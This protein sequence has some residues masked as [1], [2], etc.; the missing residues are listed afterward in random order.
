MVR[1]IIL[2]VI[3]AAIIYAYIKYIERKS[4]FFPTDIISATPELVGLPFQDVYL[5][6]QDGITIHGWFLPRK[7]ARYTIL[8]LHGNGGNVG[9]RLEKLLLLYGAGVNIFIIDYRGFGRSKGRPSEGGVYL[10]AQAS[11]DYLLKNK[12]MSPEKIILYGESLGGAVAIDLAK[13]R[14]VG[15]LIV[16][17]SFSR[18]QDMAKVF[19]PFLPAFLFA[20]TF[21]SL[22][23]IDAIRAPTLFIHSIDDE[24][25]P[26]RLAQKLYNAAPVPKEF[27]QIRGSHNTAFL[28]SKEKY[29][30]SLSSYLERLP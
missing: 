12:G 9:H 17:G 6:T 7:D 1:I 3:C 2:I 30:T 13:R 5:D 23:K 25:V 8:F 4:I 21:D 29:L 14:E 10:D 20:H 28:D 11:Y 16:E 19:Y 24:I 22:A 27:I 15:V 18:A 26:L